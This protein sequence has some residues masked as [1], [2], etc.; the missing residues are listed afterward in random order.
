MGGIGTEAGRR[1][2]R[3]VATA[4]RGRR[5]GAGERVAACVPGPFWSS[6]AGP[7]S[8]RGAVFHPFPLALHVED[9]P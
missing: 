5:M 9:M 2:V 3:V 6:S 8:R 1:A 7:E 4:G